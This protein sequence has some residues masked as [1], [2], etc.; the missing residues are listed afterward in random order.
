MSAPDE[1]LSVKL[2]PDTQP[3]EIL[4]TPVTHVTLAQ[5]P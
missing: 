1:L 2:G 3:P 4:Y 5:I